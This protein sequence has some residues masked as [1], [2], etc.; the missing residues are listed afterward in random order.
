MSTIK[1]AFYVAQFDKYFEYIYIE[2]FIY[3]VESEKERVRD[4]MEK[5]WN[6]IN[7]HTSQHFPILMK[8]NN[9]NGKQHT[10]VEVGGRLKNGNICEKKLLIKVVRWISEAISR[11][12]DS[13]HKTWYNYYY[14]S[15]R[16]SSWCF[17][18]LIINPIIYF[19]G[20]FK[21]F[22]PIISRL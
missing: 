6:W 3:N 1:K 18:V 5:P 17:H 9:E 15:Y 2:S 16:E 12:I 13:M 22:F 19:S 21:C 8:I 4:R 20:R 14:S 11:F 10:V 7:G